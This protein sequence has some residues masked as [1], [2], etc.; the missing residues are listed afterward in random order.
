MTKQDF[1]LFQSVRHTM[2]LLQQSSTIDLYTEEEVP[3]GIQ[4]RILEEAHDKAFLQASECNSKP[5]EFTTVSGVT[6]TCIA[7]VERGGIPVVGNFRSLVRQDLYY[8]DLKATII[9]AEK[10]SDQAFHRVAWNAY[11]KAFKKLSR[12]R[13]IS[14]V[15]ISH[16]LWQTNAKNFRFYGSSATCPCCKISDETFAHVL[17]CPLPAVVEA[18]QDLLATYRTA[19]QDC[20]TPDTLIEAVIHGI[21]SWTQIAQG[22]IH[23]HAPPP[24]RIAQLH[25]QPNKNKQSRSVGRHSFAGE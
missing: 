17:T 25:S 3:Q 13:Q 16:R 10:W 14:Y 20:G 24:Y 6:S 21:T 7:S 8:E 2:Q 12:P 11:S 1:D 9:K 23:R 5:A 15:K 19:L 22:V 18:R 4:S